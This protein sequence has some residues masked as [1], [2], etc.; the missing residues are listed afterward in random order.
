MKLF[1]EYREIY[2]IYMS[3]YELALCQRFN[4]EIHG[5]NEN[6]SSPNIKEHYLCLFTFE[7]TPLG[8]FESAIALSKYYCATIEIVETV[9]LEP[10]QE[11]IA[12]YKTF[13]LRI[14][15]SYIRKWLIR[16]RFTRSARMYS[17]LLQR[18][19]RPLNISL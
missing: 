4:P 6:T 12:I 1:Y 10:G 14:F 5:C 8:L 3:R 18:E 17:Y 11:C 13:W 2:I 16:R 15:Q 9:L 19:H 7:I